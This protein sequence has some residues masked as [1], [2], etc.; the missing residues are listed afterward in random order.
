MVIKE[1]LKKLLNIPRILFKRFP[2]SISTSIISSILIVIFFEKELL[3]DIFVFLIFLGIGSLFTEI[4][5]SNKVIKYSSYGISLIVAIILNKYVV[6]LNQLSM[7]LAIIYGI[8]LFIIGLLKLF[9]DSKL[10]LNEYVVR[11]ASTTFKVQVISSIISAGLLLIGGI[12]ITLFSVS[13]LLIIRLELLFGGIFVLPALIYTFAE[14]KEKAWDFIKFAIKNL[15]SVILFISFAIVYI[16][17]LKI[18]I[19]FKVPS[20]HIFRI[21]SIL[22]A[23]GLPT[24]TMISSFKDDNLIVKINNKL[25]IIF[26]PLVFLQIYSMGIRIINN[27]ITIS[28]YFGICLLIF[29]IVY[30]IIYIVKKEKVYLTA[31]IIIILS[32]VGIIIPQINATDLTVNSQY[33]R[34]INY[35][36]K[37]DLTTKERHSMYD[38][39]RYLMRIDK[40]RSLIVNNLTNEQIEYIMEE[41]IIDYSCYY[42]NLDSINNI[43]ISGY[44]LLN[45]FWI[46]EFNKKESFDIFKKITIN[47]HVV[48][49]ESYLTK[50]KESNNPDNYLL[51]NNIIKND[52][53]KIIFTNLDVCFE[54][55][56]VQNY[57]ISGYILEK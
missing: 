28:R 45:A 39:Y 26:I 23:L 41:K 20:N 34:I 2:V 4:M 44:R 53:Y 21:I 56:M 46:E 11:V 32:I 24:W 5:F 29:E 14:T 48:D 17:M 3:S 12:I 57:S 15:L 51:K 8:T 38:I 22:F 1:Y 27:G 30:L 25:P 43:D 37:K 13:D 10:T 49:L 35:L 50:F 55:S 47:N 18:I 52:N 54:E 7:K 42:S 36:N 16:Y 33:H 31:Y 9:K 6:E 19:T 40:G